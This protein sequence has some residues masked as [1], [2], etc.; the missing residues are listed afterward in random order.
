MVFPHEADGLLHRETQLCSLKH[1]L[2]WRLFLRLARAHPRSKNVATE[3]LIHPR[4]RSPSFDVYTGPG[5]RMVSVAMASMDRLN[6][7][8]CNA[9]AGRTTPRGVS[10]ARPGND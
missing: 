5:T 9:S 2:R 3:L 7:K 4:V 1:R 8:L 10:V 6:S